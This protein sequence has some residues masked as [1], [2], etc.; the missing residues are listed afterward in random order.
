MSN[1]IFDRIIVN[2]YSISILTN[3]GKI[4]GI[5]RHGFTYYPLKNQEKYQILLSNDNPSRCDAHVYV[6]KK[7]L[8]IYRIGP[9][10]K[11]TLSS[12]D[13]VFT[14]NKAPWIS[15]ICGEMNNGLVKVVFKPEAGVCGYGCIPEYE[16]YCTHY[17]KT[18]DV[19][20]SCDDTWS[21]QFQSSLGTLGRVVNG[22]NKKMNRRVPTI[23]D[24]D[25]ARITTHQARLVSG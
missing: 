6:G 13:F 4:K 10:K 9:R 23:K 25:H 15:T 7:N 2:N 21:A 16:D 22:S 1:I 20:K 17:N 5:D 24:F 12:K 11:L 18:T 14:D 19:N 8:G 3:R